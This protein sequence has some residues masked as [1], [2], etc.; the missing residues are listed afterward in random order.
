MEKYS[1]V[2]LDKKQQILEEYQPGVRGK[3]FLALAKRHS[4]ESG[5]KTIRNWYQKW[6]GTKESLEKESGGDRRS[7]LSDKEKKTHILG[8]IAKRAKK[9]PADYREVQENV[10]SKTGKQMAIKS[11]RRIGKELGVTSKK[12]KRKT[13]IEGKFFDGYLVHFVLDSKDYG[14]W[15]A[16]FRRKC[17][18]V[19]K[20]R[21]VFIDGTGMRAE[22]RKLKGLAPKGKA[23]VTKA[24]KPEKY[25]PRV[26][27]YGAISF[28]APLACETVTSAER[29]TITNTR[30]RKKGVKGY[31]KSMLKN[32]LQKKLAAKI[33]KMKAT[34]VIIGLDK[35]LHLKKEEVLESI[36]A[37]GAQNISDAWIFPTSTAKYV[38]PLD[39]SLWHSLKERVRARKPQSEDETAAA[40]KEEFMAMSEADIKGYYRHCALTQGSDPR[41]DLQ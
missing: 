19:A 2:S 9:D 11:I 41:K 39:N 37:G 3:G 8:F 26:D 36:R 31:T 17:Q 34:Q 24:S 4:I 29:K 22:P 13:P 30:T 15:V 33:K 18:R 20:N 32:F 27:M 5:P 16:Q 10:E 7:I 1:T 40:M 6:D 12:T 14:E 35:G 23:A 38:N 28:T 21:L 25:E